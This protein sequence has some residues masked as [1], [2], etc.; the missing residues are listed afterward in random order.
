MPDAVIIPDGD[1]PEAE[2]AMTAA[3][4]AAV[5]EG[6]AEVR[7]QLA[8]EHAAEAEGAAEV[9]LLA[10]EENAKTG[11]A[12]IEAQAS[13]EQSAE[14][15]KSSA[16]L[17]LQALEAQ[18]GAFNALREELAAARETQ[19]PAVVSESR[20]APERTPGRKQAKWVRRL[21]S[22]SPCCSTS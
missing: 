2:T 14:V 19:R 9:A 20:P 12:V 3:H 5:A 16:D 10:A 18:T 17:V 4:D 22:A 21:C 6:G 11:L 15:A 7:A 8:A 13:A 1:A